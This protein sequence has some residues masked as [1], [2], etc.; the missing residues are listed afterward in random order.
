MR[1]LVVEDSAILR[2]SITTALERTGHVVDAVGDGRQGWIY[3]SRN[4]YDAVVLDR[5][6]PEIDGVEVLKRLRAEGHAV[7]VLLLTVRGTV[8]DRVEGLRAGADDYLTKPFD[9]AELIA[10]V[11]ALGRR[12]YSTKSPLLQ[13]GPLSFDTAAREVRHGLEL[14]DLTRREYDLLHYLAMRRGEVVSRMEIEDHMY[15][16]H[17]LP[18]SNTV[19]ALVCNV[20][21]KL[22]AL[23]C[24]EAIETRRGNG[25]VL[26]AAK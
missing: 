25:Y 16:E 12:R 24:M 9:M 26:G 8:P 10:R 14:V 23:D 17:S 21:K 11:E 6:L 13:V 3:A 22:R 15:N 5:L 1:L 2:F 7:H 19:E 4:D 20:R 18:N